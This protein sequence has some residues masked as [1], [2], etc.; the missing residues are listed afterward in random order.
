MKL[1]KIPSIEMYINP[2]HIS[3]I[4]IDDYRGID[5]KLKKG[6]FCDADFGVYVV[7]NFSA[8]GS[9]AEKFF[10]FKDEIEAKSFLNKLLKAF[11]EA[12]K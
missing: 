1:I 2:N 3:E 9:V 6:C 5:E 10:P 4:R 12:N 7:F 8:N 11:K